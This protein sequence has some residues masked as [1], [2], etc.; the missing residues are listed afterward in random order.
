MKQVVQSYKR[1]G[2]EQKIAVLKLEIDY[3]LATLYDALLEGDLNT[4]NKCKRKLEKL[5]LELIRLE[6]LL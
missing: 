3:E 1:N 6:V 4:V 5:R 2:V